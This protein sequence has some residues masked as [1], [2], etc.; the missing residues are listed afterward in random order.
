MGESANKII[1][2]FSV[3]RYPADNEAILSGFQYTGTLQIMKQ[4]CHGFLPIF[5]D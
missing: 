1:L 3:H 5:E 2:T 4:Y